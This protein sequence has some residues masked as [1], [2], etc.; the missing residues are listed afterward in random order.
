M[1]INYK[2]KK[3]S[4]CNKKFAPRSSTQEWCDECLTKKCEYCDNAFHVG[5]KNKFESARF[6]SRSCT[7]KYRAEHYTGELAANYKNGNRLKVVTSCSYCGKAIYKEKQFVDKFVN[8]FCNRKCQI[9][10]YRQHSDEHKGENSHRYSQI[11]Q[12]V[13]GAVNPLRYIGA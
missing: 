1:S 11:E 9:S 7:A 2:P 8:V 12:D 5:K 6:C 13:S 10:Y 4:K 3:C